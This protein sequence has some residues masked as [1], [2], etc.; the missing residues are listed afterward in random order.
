MQDFEASAI[1]AGIRL[2][3]RLTNSWGDSGGRRG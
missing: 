1:G 3:V 2:A